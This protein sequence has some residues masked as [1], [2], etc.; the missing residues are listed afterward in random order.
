MTITKLKYVT[1]FTSFLLGSIAFL[2]TLNFNINYKISIFEID[3]YTYINYYSPINTLS[4]ND[5]ILF[6]EKDMYHVDTYLSNDICNH[7]IT[8]SSH[9]IPYS[10]YIGRILIILPFIIPFQ[11]ISNSFYILSTILIVICFI[12]LHHLKY[13]PNIKNI[14]LLLSKIHS[15]EHRSLHS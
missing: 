5:I 6:N 3:N 8:T 7:Y 2:L 4:Q 14:M 11:T 15:K 1:N 9:Q 12:K 10:S 13:L